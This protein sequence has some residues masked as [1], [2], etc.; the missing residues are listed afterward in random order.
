[1]PCYIT[2]NPWVA[3]Q[4]AKVMDLSLAATLV[5]NDWRITNNS[6]VFMTLQVVVGYIQD[7]LCK[8]MLN[9]DADIPD[10]DLNEPFYIVGPCFCQQRPSESL[11]FLQNTELDLAD[12]AFTSLK[13]SNACEKRYVTH[14]HTP[15][16]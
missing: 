2:T 9:P 3:T 14:K 12:W 13:P 7:M 10:F 16:K 11:I 1:M 6:Y 4:Y 15:I 5:P 8:S